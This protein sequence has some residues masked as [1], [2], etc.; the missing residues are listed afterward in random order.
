MRRKNTVTRKM[1]D[2]GKVS[3][4]VQVVEQNAVDAPVKDVKWNA[5]QVETVP[6][7][8]ND[9]GQGHPVILRTFEYS[10]NPNLPKEIKIT[11]Q[12]IFESHQFQISAALWADGLEPLF[13]IKPPKVQISKKLKNYRIFVLCKP[14]AGQVVADKIHVLQ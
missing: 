7:R 14:R 3:E 11:K 12:K 2:D 5:N 9:P 1:E 4:S 13:G 8:V 6:V 10:I